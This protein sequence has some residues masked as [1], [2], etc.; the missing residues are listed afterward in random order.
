MKK[1]LAHGV[2]RGSMQNCMIRHDGWCDRL[3]GRGE[4][5][6][7]PE[8]EIIKS[9]TSEDWLATYLALRNYGRGEIH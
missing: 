9:E 4:C 8:V 3:N 6:C 7:D 2:E 5:N 1:I